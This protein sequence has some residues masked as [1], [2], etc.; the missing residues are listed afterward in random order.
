MYYPKSQL[1]I[2]QYT[3]GGEYY[4]I[5]TG[6]PY[7]G[8]FHIIG[9]STYITGKNP[10][11]T[12]TKALTLTPPAPPED[13]DGVFPKNEI[14]IQNVNYESF[15]VGNSTNNQI[16]GITPKVTI[17]QNRTIPSF[18]SP[19]PLKKDY[20]IGEFQRYFCKKNN[21]IFYLEIDKKTFKSLQSEEPFI[22]FDL[23]TPLSI[24]WSISG[25][26]EQV[27]NT[28][29]KITTLKERN[30]QFYGFVNFFKNNWLKYYNSPSKKFPNPP[31]TTSP[32][33]GGGSGY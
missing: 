1:K 19:L 25:K 23:Y 33:S 31:Q 13:T 32:S 21:E 28:N 3:N 7:I 14:V 2:N 18:T 27:F 15:I 26:K 22:A 10:Q 8:D 29:K 30:S 6:E 11:D 24:P 4:L 20:L 16:Y 12:P 17:S 9:G 5:S